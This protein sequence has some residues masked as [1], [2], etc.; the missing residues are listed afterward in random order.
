MS[1]HIC[2]TWPWPAGAALL[3]MA[4]SRGEAPRDSVIAVFL[5]SVVVIIFG[6]C[7]LK[8]LF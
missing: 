1:G 5:V 6:D 8:K 2:R 7:F 4:S 3:A